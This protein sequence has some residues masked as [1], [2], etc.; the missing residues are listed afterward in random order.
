MKYTVRLNQNEIFSN[1]SI[2]ECVKVCLKHID[3][4][5]SFKK[6]NMLNHIEIYK[7]DKRVWNSKLAT[8]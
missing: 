6:F 3:I 1:N 2:T 7:G 5:G 8:I 4:Q